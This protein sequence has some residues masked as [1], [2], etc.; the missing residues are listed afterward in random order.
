MQPL[1][2][3]QLCEGIRTDARSGDQPVTYVRE[4]AWA[5]SDPA[6]F[7]QSCNRIGPVHEGEY[8]DDATEVEGPPNLIWHNHEV[9]TQ[10]SPEDFGNDV[11]A[12][13]VS[14]TTALGDDTGVEA[15]GVL[16]EGPSND[17]VIAVGPKGIDNDVNG[18]LA[19]PAATWLATPPDAQR[20]GDDAVQV[21]SPLA[22]RP[23]GQVIQSIW[24]PCLSGEEMANSIMCRFQIPA[25]AGQTR[26][27]ASSS[28][29]GPNVV[30]A[31]WAPL[32]ADAVRAAS[33]FGMPPPASQPSWN[34]QPLQPPPLASPPPKVPPV[35]PPAASFAGGAEAP[36]AKAQAP[37]AKAPACLVE[38]HTV[39]HHYTVRSDVEDVHGTRWAGWAFLTHEQYLN[40]WTSWYSDDFMHIF[41]M[42]LQGR[43]RGTLTW[44]ALAA[45]DPPRA[46]PAPPLLPGS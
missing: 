41:S 45:L 27:S 9:G 40:G 21:N 14:C 35:T 39:H 30:A 12:P 1:R 2:L 18:Q 46:S 19:P 31:R 38:Q 23:P 25:G 15:V 33:P 22:T 43:R 34:A 44:A 24:E 5:M 36:P 17:V 6:D 37:L 16:S 7:S 4:F 11:G 10:V 26:G 8:T 42:R 32:T 20:D 3:N 13:P 29:M 28:G